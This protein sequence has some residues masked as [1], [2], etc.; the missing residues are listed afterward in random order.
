MN[1]LPNCV[2]KLSR[3]NFADDTNLFFSSDNLKQRES[4]MNQEL[5]QIYDYCALNK[6][7]IYT[8][9]TNYMLVSSSRCDPKINITGIEQKDYI[10]IWEFI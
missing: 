6:L 8:A 1:D 9:N 2:D 4:L 3:R 5:R 7:P 10:S